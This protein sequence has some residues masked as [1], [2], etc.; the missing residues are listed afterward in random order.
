[1]PP[2]A[3]QA[4][5]RDASDLQ[6]RSDALRKFTRLLVEQPDHLRT[7]NAAT[8]QRHLQCHEGVTPVS[9]FIVRIQNLVV[10]ARASSATAQPTSSRNRSSS[11]SR[12]T[13]TRA[14]FSR[15]ATT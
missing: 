11:V 8:Q 3:V 13:R 5:H 10:V 15:T 1:R 2:G 9:S 7:H 6:G 12:R 14:F 4:A